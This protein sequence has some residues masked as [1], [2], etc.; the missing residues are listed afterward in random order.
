MFRSLLASRRAHAVDR[1]ANLLLRVLHVVVPPD[2]DRRE[3]RQ[4]ADDDLGGVDQLRRQLAV[5]YD[6]NAELH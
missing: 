1:P 4:I 6:D 3:M 2:R 5:R